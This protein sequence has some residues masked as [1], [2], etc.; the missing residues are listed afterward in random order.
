[1]NSTN[2]LNPVTGKPLQHTVIKHSSLL[3]PFVSC[4]ENKVLELQ[5]LGS[6]SQHLFSLDLMNWLNQLE[7]PSLAILS[8]LVSFNT[9]AYW[10]HL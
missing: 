9:L 6:Y 7:Y 2:K 3:D 4:R 5:S 1:M 8:T 10:A